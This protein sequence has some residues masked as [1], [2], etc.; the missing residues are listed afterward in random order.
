[1]I[2][3]PLKK[4]SLDFAREPLIFTEDRI[5]MKRWAVKAPQN[6]AVMERW[7]TP[8]LQRQIDLLEV[9]DKDVLEIGFGMGITAA[10]IQRAEP[11]S[12]TIIECHPQVINYA[13]S[14]FPY[15]DKVNL[16]GDFWQNVIMGMGKFDRIF[17]DPHADDYDAFFQIVEMKLREEGLFSYFHWENFHRKESSYNVEREPFEI[18]RDFINGSLKDITVQIPLYRKTPSSKFLK[19]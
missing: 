15:I 19:S 6:S 18:T 8:M 10:M 1:M 17:F 12:H 5:L 16:V 3:I 7:E 11:R 9:K 4:Q 13:K 14:T 2:L